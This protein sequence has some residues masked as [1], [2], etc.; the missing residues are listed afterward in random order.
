MTMKFLLDTFSP[1]AVRNTL[2]YFP[3]EGVTTNPAIICR[4]HAPLKPVLLELR[5]LL[6]GKMLH[7]QTLQTTADD[8]IKEAIALKNL[9]SRTEGDF[10]VKLPAVKEG[11]KACRELKQLGVGVTMTAVFSPAQAL[12]CARAGADFVAPYVNKLD[13]AGDG[14][15]C[16]SETV[17]L[18][19][20][21][22]LKTKVL[23]ASFRNVSQVRRIALSGSHYITLPAAFYEKLISHPMTEMAIEGF[24]NDWNTEY[25]NKLPLDML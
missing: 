7:V 14:E 17:K 8:M 19:G 12:I 18:F 4:E 24:K 5:E 25:G 2:E 9:L 20:I 10:F 16:V 11:L 3:I 13:D 21:F 6:A 23:S 15:N 1:E 22:G